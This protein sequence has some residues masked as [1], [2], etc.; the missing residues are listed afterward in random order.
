MRRSR[1]AKIFT[2][3]GQICEKDEGKTRQ[4]GSHL[5]IF[6]RLKSLHSIAPLYAELQRRGLAGAIGDER[7]IQ[8]PVLPLRDSRGRSQ[9]TVTAKETGDRPE[10][11]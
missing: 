11:S 8:I 3:G 5:V 1:K 6:L 7:R 2:Q 10:D 9:G 4:R